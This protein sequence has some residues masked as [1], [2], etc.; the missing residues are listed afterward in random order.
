MLFSLVSCFF[1]VTALLFPSFANASSGVNVM[2]IM[3]GGMDMY[4]SSTAT[5]TALLQIDLFDTSGGILNTVKVNLDKDPNWQTFVPATDLAALSGTVSAGFALYKDTNAIGSFVAGVDQLIGTQPTVWPAMGTQT[6][7]N[8]NYWQLT[9]TGINQSISTSATTM[10]RLFVV[11][12]PALVDQDPIHAFMLRI[13]QGGIMTTGGS[14][15]NF[16]LNMDRPM[17]NLGRMTMESLQVQRVCL[18]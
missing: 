4:L 3:T 18:F 1:A 10:T 6:I 7:G 2:P 17:M 13:P 5:P 14:I 16:P 9:F 11:G 15:G 8:M 12:K